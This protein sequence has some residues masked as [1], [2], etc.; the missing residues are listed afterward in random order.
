MAQTSKYY[1]E[2]K[3]ISRDSGVTWIAT[4]QY[5]KGRWYENDSSDC[6]Q[7]E[8]IYEWRTIDISTDYECDGV[9]KHYKERKYESFN[10]G[11]TW[12]ATNDYRIGSLYQANSVDC[13]Y[14]PTVKFQAWYSDGTTYSAAC[15]SSTELTTATT[16]A[17]TTPYSAMTSAEI[18]DCITNIR[19]FTFAYFDSLSSVTI[20]NSVTSLGLG[21][22][23]SC[24]SLSSITIPNSVT[25]IGSQLFNGCSSLTN[26]TLGNGI[27]SISD[28]TFQNCTSLSSITIPNSV[29][30]IGN[31]VFGHCSGLTSVTIPDSVTSIGYSTFRYC[32]S[33]SS[34]TIG[35]GITSIGNSTFSRCS[36]TFNLTV[37]ATVPPLLGSY[38]FDY[39]RTLTIYV[40]SQSLDR[41]KTAGGWSD[42]A[43]KIQPIA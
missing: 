5:R 18:G 34:V 25:S 41:Y 36:D 14:V 3:Y 16:Q 11:T 12:V 43:N 23:Q 27:T 1:K 35:S 24:I 30:S 31:W 13:G 21:T 10:N 32:S 39:I 20:P 17:H 19:Y 9:D 22:F 2:E 38:V 8:P 29:T 37:E 15:D 7:G 28:T 6:S 40:P 42:Y 4:G 26:V 33:L